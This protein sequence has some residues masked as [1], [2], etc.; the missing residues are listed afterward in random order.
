[1]PNYRNTCTSQSKINS[2]DVRGLRS[3][4]HGNDDN[5]MKI[6]Q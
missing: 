3:T 6:D 4:R 2:A 5:D 1:M